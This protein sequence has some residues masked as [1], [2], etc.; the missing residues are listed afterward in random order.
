MKSPSNSILIRL[1]TYIQQNRNYQFFIG[2]PLDNSTQWMR[3]VKFDRTNLQVEQGLILNHKDVLA[4]IVA[5]PSGEILDAENIFY[6]L[7]RG[8][9]FI[10]KEEKR[11]QKIL[12]P[13][14]LKFGNRCLKVVHQKN[15]RDRRKNY[16]NTILIN[17][18]NERIRVKKFAAYSRYGSIYIL[19]TVTGGY[20]S[21]KQ[22]KEWYDIDGDG[23][24]EPGQIIT[25]RNNNGISS[26]YW[27]YFCV[28]ESNKEFVAGELFPGARLWWKFW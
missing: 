24:I 4:F 17:L 11:L 16:Y 25:D 10:G 3:V 19:S 1:K 23:W 8:I 22:F 9:N 12:V 5:Y 7:P 14:N 2:Y 26:C 28:S 15:A 20:F 6:P 21:E 13:E 27:V 18:C